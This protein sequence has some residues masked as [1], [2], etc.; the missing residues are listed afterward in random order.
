MV[1]SLQVFLY[2]MSD[3]FR[4]KAIKGMKLQLVGE[5]FLRA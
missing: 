2:S 3:S 1:S 4:F 5:T